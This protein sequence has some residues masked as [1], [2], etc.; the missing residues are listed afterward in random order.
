[1]RIPHFAPHSNSKRRCANLIQVRTALAILIIAAFS[2]LPFYV[3]AQTSG[4]TASGRNKAHDLIS[5]SDA[6]AYIVYRDAEGN[7]GCRLAGPGELP[8]MQDS[9]ADGLHQI[10]HLELL[11]KDSNVIQG[12]NGLTI[13]LRGTTQLDQFP[14]AKAA[15]AAAAAK[16]EAL[17]RDQITIVIDVDFGPTNFGAPYGDTTLGS[18]SS[19]VILVPSYSSLRTSLLNHASN[20]EELTTLNAL[21]AG[22]SVPTD[23]GDVSQ[24]EVLTPQARA[25]GRLDA[26]ANPDPTPDPTGP[27]GK[28]IDAFGNAPSIGF[29]SKFSFDFNSSDGVTPNTTDFD[30]VAVHEMG[31]VLGF[32]SE[33]GVRDLDAAAPLRLT[34]W[35]LFRLR[36]GATLAGFSTLQRVLSTGGEQ[37]YFDGS[38]ELRLSTGNPLGN[39]GDGQQGSHWKDNVQNGGIFIGIMDPTLARGVHEEMSANDIRAMNFFGYLVGSGPA[40]PPNDNFSNAVTLQ[41]SSGTVTGTNSGATKE[42]GE[43]VNPPDTGGGRSVW[44]NWTPSSSGQATIDTNGSTF[45]TTLA[46]YTGSSVSA[47]TVIASNDDI[48]PLSAPPPRNIQS[49]VTFPVTAGTTYR[50]QVDGFD[51]DIGSIT[52]HWSGPAGPLPTAQFTITSATVDENVGG[53]VIAVSRTGDLTSAVSV[54]YFTSDGTASVGQQDYFPV[55]GRLDFASGDAVKTFIVPINN[56]TSAEANETFNIGLN[57]PSNGVSIGSPNSLVITIRDDDTFQPNSVQ[58]TAANQTL[59]ETPNQTTSVNVTVIRSGSFSGPASI[60][61]AT[62][63]GPAGGASERSDYLA[64]VG[65]LRFAPGESS[66]TITVFIVDDRYLE[67][68]ETFS[69]TLSNPVGCTLGS[70]QTFTVTINS[71]DATNGPNPIRDPNFD[72]D[73]FVRE[74]YVDF[75]NRGADASGLAYWKNEIDSCTSQECREIKR[76]NVSAAFFVSIEF[77]ETGYLVYKTHQAAFNRGQNLKLRTFLSDARQIGSGVVIGDPGA[78]AQLEANKQKFFKDFVQRPE[79]IQAYPLTMTAF[80]FVNNLNN[81]TYDPLSPGAGALTPSQINA[82]VAPLSFNPAS[83]D[84][85]AQALRS[86]AENSLFS[87]RQF[88]KAFVLMQYFGYLRRNPNDAPELGLDFSGYNFWLTK[89]NDFNGNYINAEMV[90]AFL[91]STEYQQRFGP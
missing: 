66:K 12:T 4:A 76:I 91:D 70:Q 84:L 10:N 33:M 29:N 43:P 72:T 17:I 46:V 64:A 52:L 13:I 37:V 35:D 30:S 20:Q 78:D 87:T 1:V 23:L 26:N 7:V 9:A 39:G 50:I 63:D 25:L 34:V 55:S 32:A 53:A 8:P 79:F 3:G 86:I 69:L 75:F 27:G 44:Y 5:T 56:D 60:D 89:L 81:N 77:K 22:S 15:F 68:P 19:H 67:N 2:S 21:P 59:T 11:S 71:N 6:P 47:L 24:A 80:D 74:Q 40:A 16:W 58:F 54:G 49:S 57:N 62:A 14:E 28:S 31:H 61:Y 85:R 45:D 36:P 42:A 82:L 41:G 65:T 90:K 48:S 83:P 38:P 51:A 88:N 73:F 18:T